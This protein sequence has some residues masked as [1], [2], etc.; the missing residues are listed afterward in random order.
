MLLCLLVVLAVAAAMIWALWQFVY[1]DCDLETLVLTKFGRSIDKFKGK[2]VWITGASSGVG[3]GL[4]YVLA[5][6]GAKLVLSGT[7]QERLDKVKQ[8]CLN[9]S[10]SDKNDVLTLQ[11]D[12]TDSSCHQE[13]L[14]QVL[15]HFKK[16]D[17][18][19]NNAGRS[20]RAFFHEIDLDVDKA[21]FEVNVFSL[22]N[23]TRV[24]LKYYFESNPD[25][26]IAVTSSTAGL[27]GVPYSASYTGSKHALHG[28]FECLRME[29]GSKNIGITMLCLGPVFSNVAANAF[30]GKIEEKSPVTHA[31]NAHRM[32]TSRAAY[33][34]AVATI[35]RLDEAWITIQPVLT[36][37]YF[38]QY[39][40]AVARKLMPRFM[41]VE[42]MNRIREGK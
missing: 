18:L 5:S 36:L 15:K 41:T 23:L 12:M 39:L 33:L 7:N 19:V 35:N 40:P 10:K 13:K 25:G 16:L 27:M 38:N 14:D 24:V 9:I 29:L 26:Q 4:A 6:T 8:Q 3:E 28:Y 11:F 2:V 30:T 34:M 22:I 31:A 21:L 37:H 1:L 32:D 42:R 17:V 20:Q